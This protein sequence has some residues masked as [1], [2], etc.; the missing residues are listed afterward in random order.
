MEGTIIYQL[1]IDHYLSGSSTISKLYFDRFQAGFTA[2]MSLLQDTVDVEQF[3]L[4]KQLATNPLSRVMLP[5]DLKFECG[6]DRLAWH[7][8]ELGHESLQVTLYGIGERTSY[9][10][11]LNIPY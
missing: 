11:H 2:L 5:D 10:L 4:L 9:R 3:P 8:D 7:R 6:L 1:V